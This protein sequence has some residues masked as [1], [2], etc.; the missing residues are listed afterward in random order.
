MKK[1]SPCWTFREEKVEDRGGRGGRCH[2]CAPGS[3]HEPPAWAGGTWT[4]K[5][6]MK[7]RTY[8]CVTTNVPTYCWYGSGQ[9]WAQAEGS[10]LGRARGH[11]GLSW[12]QGRH[13][14]ENVG[15]IKKKW[16]W[17]WMLWS[18]SERESE[19]E[20]GSEEHMGTGTWVDL[21]LGTAKYYE[22]LWW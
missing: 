8:K 12:S 2:L 5:D 11:G 15:M 19:S 4:L 14:K 10:Q 1:F 17:N 18:T 22:E 6:I 20:K 16:K 21:K 13:C 7:K 3:W 9:G